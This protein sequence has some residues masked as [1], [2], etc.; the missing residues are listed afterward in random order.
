MS[1]G[2][3]ISSSFSHPLVILVLAAP[4]LQRPVLYCIQVGCMLACLIVETILDHGLKIDFRHIRWMVISYVVLF[5]A[6]TGGM[7]GVATNAGRR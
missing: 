5:F 7:L 2:W 1:I 6:S 3:V 4:H